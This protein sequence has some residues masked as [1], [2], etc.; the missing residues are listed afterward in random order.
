MS[1][2]AAALPLNPL[3][4]AATAAGGLGRGVGG[5]SDQLRKL[6]SDIRRA[7]SGVNRVGPA[8]RTSLPALQQL[9][10]GASTAAASANKV[11]RSNAAGG[12]R[13]FGAA[14]SRARASVAKLG[15][16]PLAAVLGL[17][18]S[19]VDV[20]ALLS[21]LMGRFGTV[22]TIA[23][24]A[25]TAVNTAMRANPLG[26]VLGIVIPLAAFLIEYAMSTKTGQRIARQAFDAALRGIR[27]AI[28]VIGPVLKAVGNGVRAAFRTVRSLIG[29]ALRGIGAAI[30]GISRAGSAIRSAVTA[31]RSIASRAFRGLKSAVERPLKWV[32]DNV[33]K[34]FTRAKDAVSKTLRGIG[35]FLESGA[36]TVLGVIKGPIN[37]LIAF[38]NWV[39]DGLGKLSVNILGKKF[40]VD[41]DKIPMLAD[42]GVV[43]PLDNG[44]TPRIAPAEDLDHRPVSTGPEI[45]HGPRRIAHFREEPGAGPRAVAEDLLFLATSA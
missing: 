15:G 21:G 13:R 9:R 29:G 28:A 32:R 4:N 8:L 10:N 43:F 11:A 45:P 34:F 36:Q 31:L 27:S 22:L 30:G 25:M 14:A 20:A 19:M 39:I 23:S 5:V 6:T 12:V 7:A 38:A 33:P 44:G 24:V 1:A 41:L 16:G 18:V 42:G 35:D 3:R 37:G 17:I 26:F 2:L 40:G